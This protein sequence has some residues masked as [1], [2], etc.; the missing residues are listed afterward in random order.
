ML[1]GKKVDNRIGCMKGLRDGGKP[2]R[3]TKL[4]IQQMKL[5]PNINLEEWLI[6]LW[7]RLLINAKTMARIQQILE[8]GYGLDTG[9]KAVSN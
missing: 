4:P 1:T 9:D 3:S 6:F 8:D 7:E 2:Q 5:A